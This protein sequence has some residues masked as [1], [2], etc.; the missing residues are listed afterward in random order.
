[1]NL[2][3][4]AAVL[5]PHDVAIHPNFRDESYSQEPVGQLASLVIGGDWRRPLHDG[6]IADEAVTYTERSFN[7]ETIAEGAEG[8]IQQA[9]LAGEA[10]L[11]ARRHWCSSPAALWQ[12]WRST[13]S[14]IPF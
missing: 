9:F 7:T 10:T 14:A 2:G 5:Q 12:K 13:R 4:I 8:L 1:M 6:I 11:R 3:W